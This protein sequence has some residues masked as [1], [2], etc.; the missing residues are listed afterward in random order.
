MLI[1]ATRNTTFPQ[2]LHEQQIAYISA[3]QEMTIFEPLLKESLDF[4]INFSQ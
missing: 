1:I 4:R 3:P 2:P